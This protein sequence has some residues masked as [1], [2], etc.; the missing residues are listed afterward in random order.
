M[1]SKEKRKG[2]TVQMR[3]SVMR[4]IRMAIAASG[5]RP[6]GWWEDAVLAAVPPAIR[7]GVK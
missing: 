7:K 2:F 3:P 4:A 5:K 1:E 6:G